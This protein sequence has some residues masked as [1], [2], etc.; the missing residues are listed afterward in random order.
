MTRR[1]I[2]FEE[3]YNYVGQVVFIELGDSDWIKRLRDDVANPSGF[4]LEK[5][6]VYGAFEIQL[7]GANNSHHWGFSKDYVTSGIVTVFSSEHILSNKG[8]DKCIK[9]RCAT[10]NRRDFSDMTVREFCPR[11]KF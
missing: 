11:C 9:C 2:P 5:V 4:I 7:I 6:T 3:L 10:E 8:L 1:Y